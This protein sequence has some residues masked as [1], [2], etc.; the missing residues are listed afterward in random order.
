[1]ADSWNPDNKIF[2][3]IPAQTTDLIDFPL[4][5][6]ADYMGA[7]VTN[8]NFTDFFD[9]LFLALPISVDD[10]FEGVDGDLPNETL[11]QNS[12]DVRILTNQLRLYVPPNT[13][14][15]NPSMRSLY[16]ISGDFDIQIDFYDYSTNSHAVLCQFRIK[17]SVDD[18]AYAFIGP[19]YD[20][21]NINS[22]W[23]RIQA[24][25]SACCND[26]Y[27][28][29]TY[30]D[31]QLRIERLGVTLSTYYKDTDHN[32][33]TLVQSTTFC[34]H[35][36][37]IELAGY[38]STVSFKIDC[39]FD[40]F[41][42]NSGAIVWPS[43]KK[44]K[45]VDEYD[46]QHFV[47]IENWDW[48]NKNAQ[49]HV[50][51]PLIT[52]IIDNYTK[53][54]INSNTTDGSVIFE[55]SSSA[56][57]TITVN[58][59]THHEID[60]K[61]FGSTS[62]YFDGNGDYLNLGQSS[63]WLFETANFTIDFWIK[64]TLLDNLE[65]VLGQNESEGATAASNNFV[66]Y[67]NASN[68]TAFI[69][70][71]GTTQLTVLLG[72]INDTNWHHLA[73]VR[74]NTNLIGYID[75]IQGGLTDVTGY[76]FSNEKG[77]FSIGRPGDYIH[78]EFNGYIDEFRISKGIARWTGGFTPP[79]KS[80]LEIETP[81][82][83]L[84]LYYDHTVADNISTGLDT[85]TKLLIH[86]DTFDGDV[87]FIDSSNSGHVITTKGNAH[88]ETDQY[89]FGTT[90]IMPVRISNTVGGYLNIPDSDDFNLGS[91][92]FTIDFWLYYYNSSDSPTFCGQ[93][94]Y[95]G[96]SMLNSSFRVIEHASNGF[97]FYY[98]T[99]GNTAVDI[100]FNQNVPENEWVHLAV[101]RNNTY[102]D[103]YI[104]GNSIGSYN[105]GT[106]IL[107]NSTS[108]LNIG[109]FFP[110]S[111]NG[112]VW[113]TVDGY[114]DEFR[115]SKG[116][117]RWI[118]NFTPPDKPYSTGFV[119]DT[120]SP[121][122]QQVWD[123]NFVAVYHMA[124]DPSGTTP[125]I[126]DSTSNSNHGTTYGS[127][128]SSDLVSGLT[129]KTIEFD[130]VD[131]YIIVPNDTSL[132]ITTDITIET[133]Y[134][135][136]IVK[137]MGLITKSPLNGLWSSNAYTVNTNT[138]TN[139]ASLLIGTTPTYNNSPEPSLDK[140]EILTQT[141][142]LSRILGYIDGIEGVPVNYS[143]AIPVNT[144]DITIGAYFEHSNY[145]FGGLLS[146][147]RISN[148]TRAVSWISTTNTSLKD[149][150]ITFS[151]YN[152]VYFLYSNSY[153]KDNI[154]KY[155]TQQLIASTVTVSGGAESYNY[156]S[157]FY[158]SGGQK[159]APTISGT[160]SGNE[161]YTHLDT[162]S[163]SS[164][165]WYIETTSSGKTSRS[166]D[167]DFYVR[168]LCSGICNDNRGVLSGIK[169]NLHRRTTSDL[170]GTTTTAGTGTFEIETPYNEEYYAVA[171]HP[172]TTLNALIYDHLKP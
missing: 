157:T 161:V 8:F 9:E 88:H 23:S 123:D 62:I 83:L 69:I 146:E 109:A 168:Y 167:Y 82:T 166:P 149:T 58:G 36:V 63:D 99:G 147:I 18:T 100:H 125:Q 44:F 154:K 41:K 6:N 153:P 72:D 73:V 85:F 33:W 171:L 170:I 129:G 96:S 46:K 135:T 119:G 17:S 144:S 50:K 148:I 74:N 24:P 93:G 77:N 117:A 128:T 152:A 70:S 137:N 52:G 59:N 98:Y 116:I 28:S 89:K 108:D 11:W 115:I 14:A 71:D 81:S 68:V 121:A 20:S 64:R 151:A 138:S 12:K 30:V 136:S 42:V 29:A 45:I 38:K 25:G 141:Y 40:N 162:I 90:S 163:G 126:L 26:A 51:V 165:S 60:Q 172:D 4:L 43:S 39:L 140:W 27:A 124:Q 91:S 160:S 79:I 76:D 16:E 31:G 86:S 113:G 32:S 106:T 110:E 21:T 102:L 97:S 92:D 169:V 15:T 164:Y 7:G 65:Y 155:G 159:I 19:G 3:D 112:D 134:Y 122:A 53:L 131:D 158:L 61:K 143:G 103:L 104:N 47:E 84:E 132:N 2:I 105:I 55:D 120:K 118:G 114:M 156:D 133:M 67:F 48:L 54:L 49:L 95:S 37:Y 56:N 111:H 94:D 78:L 80:Y 145:N 57:H 101:V 34:D 66:L 22:F 35:N 127:M 75:G 87:I 1:M 130:G 139:N 10:N 142:N 5:L 13:V 107:Y 150:L